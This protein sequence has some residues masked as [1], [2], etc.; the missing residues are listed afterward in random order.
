MQA[1]HEETH[2]DLILKIIPDPEASVGEDEVLGAG[3]TL[4]ILHRR[5]GNPAADAGLTGV[6][7]IH[8]REIAAGDNGEAWFPVYLYDHG[9]KRYVIGD[10]ASPHVNPFV[11]RLPQGHA[12]F[13]SGRVGSLF[14]KR[15]EFG[16][17]DL[18]PTAKRIV[19]TYTAWANGEVY[20]Y[21]IE[22]AAGEEIDSCWGYIGYDDALDAGQH[23]V[24]GHTGAVSYGD[25]LAGAAAAAGY[26]EP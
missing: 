12:E 18:Q 20:G 1:I 22:D 8:E 3:V 7:A 19:E 17:V 11:G 26:G 24:S 21:I 10:P 5:Y 13:D 25:D 4:A 15:A 6:D 23:A 16:D 2:G 9:Y 14:L